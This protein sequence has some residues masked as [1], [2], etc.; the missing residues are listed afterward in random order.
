V[1]VESVDISSL[2]LDPSNVRGHGERNVDAIKASL[3]KFGQQKPIVVDTKGVVVAGNGTVVAAQQLGW[4]QLNVVR[5]ELK[6]AEAVAYSIADNRTAELAEWKAE[7]AESL[8]GLQKDE[9]IDH[10]VTGFTDE[11]IDE[12]VVGATEPGAVVEDEVP[13]PPDEPTTKRGDLWILGEHR[14]LCGDAT[15]S[16]DRNRLVGAT[17]IN[18]LL[19]DPPYGVDYEGGHNTQKR[20]RITGDVDASMYAAFLPLWVAPVAYVWFA[21]RN[22][23]AVFA[24]VE[25][26][27][28]SVRA[29]LVWNKL[30]AHYGAF[31]AQYLQKHEPCLYCVRK[32]AAWYGP[33]NATTVWDIEQPARNEHH[34]T[35]KPLECMASPIKNS[36]KAGA[37]IADPFLGSG[38]T[39]IA[40]EQLGRKCYGLEI[41]PKYCDVIVARWEKL[42]GKKAEREVISDV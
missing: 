31:M 30:N 8:A 16:K 33:S 18:L 27:G 2:S 35:Q 20:A 26:V 15:V 37:T 4:T 24:A 10:L 34:P 23:L 13:E 1:N 14:V 25:K 28:Y 5:S 41:E 3:Q 6:G 29:L 11:E 7:L 38:T 12:L 40:A 9:S 22:G 32:G 42:T 17:P 36:T 39:L 21:G 19:T